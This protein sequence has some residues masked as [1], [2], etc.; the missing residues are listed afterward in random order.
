MNTHNRSREEQIA[1]AVETFLRHVGGTATIAQIRRALPQHAALT[2]R[3][4]ASSTTRPGEEL[5][6][7]QVRNIVC[8][9]DSEGNFVKEGRIRW[10]PGRLSLP[11]YGQG[12]L[13]N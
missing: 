5:W 2:P 9:R 4:R 8:H 7:Q 13:F 10:S 12:D 1:Q 3:D 11:G 6:E